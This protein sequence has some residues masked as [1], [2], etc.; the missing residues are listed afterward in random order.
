MSFTVVE[1]PNDH[2]CGGGSKQ[3]EGECDPKL[4]LSFAEAHTAFDEVKRMTGI[5]T[6]WQC[7]VD[8]LYMCIQPTGYC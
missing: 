6:R 8:A 3:E 7:F 5:R 2:N 4:V 1:L